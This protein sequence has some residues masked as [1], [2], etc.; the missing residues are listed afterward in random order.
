VQLQ[1]PLLMN[2][3]CDG[4]RIKPL[5][6]A[7]TTDMISLLPAPGSTKLPP[8]GLCVFS[9]SLVPHPPSPPLSPLPCDLPP[10][11]RP[12]PPLC[13]RHHRHHRRER[14][15]CV[16]I[17]QHMYELEKP[18]TCHV[19]VRLCCLCCFLK[20]SLCVRKEQEWR[21]CEHRRNEFPCL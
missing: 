9:S 4:A 15:L 1:T 6:I 18:S 8:S 11:P 7:L 14:S 21:N 19:I 3:A 13:H 12:L 20:G 2:R 17:R 16:C 10:I 5:P